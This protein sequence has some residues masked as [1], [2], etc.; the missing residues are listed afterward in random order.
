MSLQTPARNGTVDHSKRAAFTLI[1]LLVV[2]AIIAILAAMLLPALA[3]AKE[4]AKRTQCVSNLHQVSFILQMY[5]S[6]NK[7]FLPRKDPTETSSANSLW[8]LP[9]SMGDAMASA[10]PSQTNNIYKKVFYCP[11]SFT[12]V[13][14]R[15]DDYFWNYGNNNHVTSYQ[16]IISRDGSQTYGAANGVQL[17]VPKG[18]LN[19]IT[20]PFTN[21]FSVANTEMVTDIIISTG[22]GTL[23]DTFVGVTSAMPEVQ[24]SGG[25][26]GNHMAKKL[27]AGS[28]ILFM[29][30]HVEWRRFR[31]MNNPAWGVWSGGRFN[32][33]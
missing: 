11:G 33:F 26:N 16:W 17:I 19:K 12:R 7:D 27:P 2:I 31:D 4:K 10:T 29:D 14:D 15:P 28:D 8:D 30:G 22:N 18:F 3:S 5:A 1:E 9:K 24:A 23:S 20:R 6:D 32:W 21:S 25:M 13:V